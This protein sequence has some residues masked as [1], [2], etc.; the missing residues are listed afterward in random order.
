ML[1]EGSAENHE[2]DEND[3]SP[4]IA[5]SNDNMLDFVKTFEDNLDKKKIKRK[6]GLEKFFEEEQ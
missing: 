4:N 1:F 5:A 6:Q 3:F 2:L